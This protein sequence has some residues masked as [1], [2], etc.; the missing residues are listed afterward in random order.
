[1]IYA[2]SENNPNLSGAR[3]RR[4]WFTVD[5]YNSHFKPFSEKLS[6]NEF[7]SWIERI[8]VKTESDKAFRKR[9]SNQSDRVTKRF[10][11][12]AIPIFQFCKHTDLPIAY[13]T[14]Q[15]QTTQID[16]ILELVDGRRKFL[17]VTCA[18]DGHEEAWLTTYLRSR[19][20][21]PLTYDGGVKAI[22]DKIA[23][24]GELELVAV[25]SDVEINKV[26]SRVIA[27]IEK[28]SAKGYPAGTYLLVAY[29]SFHEDDT[30]EIVQLVEKHFAGRKVDFEKVYLVNRNAEI[31]QQVKIT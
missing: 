14:L 5:D 16:A 6:L 27:E 22:K 12:E 24:G 23:D 29:G 9:F 11:E 10:R 28:K 1:M 25:S 19:G 26:T 31:T 30:E 20:T 18:K 15:D 4:F 8:Q 21:A 2:K 3:L 13:I 17:E 7:L